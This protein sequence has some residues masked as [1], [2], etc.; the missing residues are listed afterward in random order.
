MNLESGAEGRVKIMIPH[1][2]EN[3][4]Q[5][6]FPEDVIELIIKEVK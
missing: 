3:D 5:R 1:E 4:E 6:L 2:N